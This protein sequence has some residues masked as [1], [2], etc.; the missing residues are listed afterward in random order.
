MGGVLVGASDTAPSFVVMALKDPLGANLDRIQIIKGWVDADGVAQERIYD[1]A[2]SDD[3]VPDPASQRVLA[4]GS[5]VDVSDASYTNTIG[6]E[7]LE[8]LWQDADFDADAEAFYYA[9]VLE[10]PTPRWSTYDAKALGVAAPEP[11]SIQERA[12]A[13]AIWFRP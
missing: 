7:T 8:A 6:A 1:V 3:R 10:I 5:T 12:I 9:R 2:A 11:E 4:V 13:S